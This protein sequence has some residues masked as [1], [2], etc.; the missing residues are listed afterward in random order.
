MLQGCVGSPDLFNLYSEIVL[1]SLEE[2]R[3]GVSINGVK[4]NNIR[5]ADDTVLVA[6][7][8]GELQD[9]INVL[10]RESEEY[11][12]SVNTKKTKCMVISK[13]KAGPECKLYLGEE[14]IEQVT[15]FNYL[16]SMLTSDGRCR[17]DIRRRI[18]ISK[19][20]FERMRP[21]LGDRKLSVGL[22]VRLI[23]TYV[24][25]TLL[26]GCESWSLTAET[27]RNIAAAEMYFYRR[28]MRVSYVDGVSNDDV[29]SR[30]QLQQRQLLPQIEQR[31]LRFLGHIIRKK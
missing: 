11:G 20:A 23:K 10:S 5:Y 29:L 17:K 12:L 26:Y 31:Q 2:V 3:A 16:G 4:L 21:I 1:K 30:V 15:E 28:M 25:S 19:S 18:A 24:W 7:S 8:E 6:S 9:L 27:K 22:R 13:Q 14:Q